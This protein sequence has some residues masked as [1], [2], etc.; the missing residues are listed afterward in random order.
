LLKEKARLPIIWF[1]N[2]TPKCFFFLLSKIRLED[3]V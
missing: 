1:K 3:F 2:I